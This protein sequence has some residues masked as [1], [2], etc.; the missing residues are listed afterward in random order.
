M[1]FLRRQK[2]TNA[3]INTLCWEA[4]TSEL[5]L[6]MHRIIAFSTDKYYCTL[7]DTECGEENKVAE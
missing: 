7:F 5:K 1:Q 4:I 2:N 3:L 6:Q